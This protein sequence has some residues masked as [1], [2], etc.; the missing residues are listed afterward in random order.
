MPRSR[1]S[2]PVPLRRWGEDQA[3]LR[4]I[5]KWFG[6]SLTPDTRQQKILLIV[7]PRRS[8]KGTIARTW[9]A[10]LGDGNVASPALSSL[11]TRFGLWPLDG[12]LLAIFKDAR[13]TGNS[14]ERIMTVE[15]LLN[16]SG[17]DSIDVEPKGL[18]AVKKKL[19]SRLVIFSNDEP[20]FHESSG[21]LAGRMNPLKL[22]E[23]YFGREDHGLG[24]RLL[25]ELP[26]ILNWAIQGLDKL[27]EDG[28]FI[29]PESAKDTRDSIADSASP[30]THFFDQ[31]CAQEIPDDREAEA[32][33]AVQEVYG[34]WVEWCRI[35][36]HSPKTDIVFSRDL[37][38]A[39]PSIETVRPGKDEKG[40][41]KR[42]YR[43][44]KLTEEGERFAR[45]AENRR[46]NRI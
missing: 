5:Q 43:G 12:K 27:R 42:R 15:R 19:F 21:A 1:R 22:T 17:E 39:F 6:Y 20:D 11:G 33:P 32:L 23:D 2:G 13:V 35:G 36:N 41:R 34:A 25:A 30:I 8:G 29:I 14:S 45:L 37:K 46:M 40:E 31:L 4:E 44:I 38:A 26:G 28:H 18:K 24:D 10:L 9:E 7:G 16:I 3:S